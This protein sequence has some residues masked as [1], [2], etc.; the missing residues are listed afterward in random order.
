M[1]PA[2]RHFCLE[3]LGNGFNATAAYKAAYPGVTDGSART[4]GWRMLANA[5]V[6][7][8]L[9]PRLERRW[10]QLQISGDEA[11]ARI[12]LDA[13]VDIRL[14]FDEQGNL[15]KPQDWPDEIVGSIK[16]VTPGPFGTKVQLVDGLAARRII[17]EQTGKL[18][19]TGDSIDALAAAI[20]GD[21]EKHGR[22]GDEPA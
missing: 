12:A 10:T 2:R 16:S 22:T 6:R 15:L 9:A 18:K 20:R 8:F 3:Y 21:L 4:N 5:D 19:T 11:L 13:T 7:A 14:L 1:L 17:L